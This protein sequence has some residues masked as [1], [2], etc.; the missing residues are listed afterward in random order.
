MNTSGHFETVREWARTAG[1]TIAGLCRHAGVNRS[2][3]DLWRIGKSAPS[4]R[5]WDKLKKA[6]EDLQAKREAV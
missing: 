4:F 1:T 5:T 6:A 3:V 2:T